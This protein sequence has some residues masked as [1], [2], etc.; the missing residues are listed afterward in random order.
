MYP[1][2]DFL[3]IPINVAKPE[4]LLYLRLYLLTYYFAMCICFVVKYQYGCKSD[5]C[6]AVSLII[7]SSSFSSFE[8]F[9]LSIMLEVVHTLRVRLGSVC[10]FSGRLGYNNG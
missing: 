3:I 4:C 1:L 2:E 5:E 6:A 7:L 8:L 9:V 10:K